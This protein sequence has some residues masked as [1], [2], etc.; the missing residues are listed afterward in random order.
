MYSRSGR[1]VRVVGGGGADPSWADI[2]GAHISSPIRG[3]R[4]IFGV[5]IG[6]RVPYL[7]MLK[8]LNQIRFDRKWTILLIFRIYLFF[9]VFK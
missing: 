6:I 9:A 2:L 5:S 3:R 4:L 7:F 8:F 1:A